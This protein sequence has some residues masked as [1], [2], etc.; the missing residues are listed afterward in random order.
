GC[1][2]ERTP[3]STTGS[4][5][6]SARA[7]RVR[8]ELTALPDVGDIPRL[9]AVDS[10]RAQGYIVDTLALADTTGTMLALE[11]GD[12][13]VANVQ[14][15]IGWTAIQKGAA[16]VALIDDSMNP[17]ILAATR[18]I[19]KCAD[20]H[21]KRVGIGSLAGGKT[22]MLNRYIESRCPG[23]KPAL[24]VMAGEGT[25]LAGLLAG[26]LD[27]AIMDLEN[28]EKVDSTRRG[29]A[30]ALVVF[31]DEYPGLTTNSLFARRELTEKYPA[32]VKDWLRA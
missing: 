18:D 28:L 6:P 32:T 12:L 4:P 29:D 7:A 9:M 15:V 16:I 1:R 21:G 13:D 24:L 25:R 19:K 20:L 10:M 8:I 31:A 3:A 2:S 30:S 11:R 5:V 23:T 17:T 22:V 26:E 14:D 27:A